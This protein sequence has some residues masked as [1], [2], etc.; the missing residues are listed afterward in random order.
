VEQALAGME[1]LRVAAH[2]AT[3][4]AAR[5]RM[6]GVTGDAGDGTVLDGDE[7]R[8]RVR[9]VVRADGAGRANN[10]PIGHCWN[11]SAL[12]HLGALS[13]LRADPDALGHT[14]GGRWPAPATRLHGASERPA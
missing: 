4:E 8:A 5:D 13:G 11:R 12:P 14:G 7:Q 10:P 1:P 2:L 6:L 3:D 9:A